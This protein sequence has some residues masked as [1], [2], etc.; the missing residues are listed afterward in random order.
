M[1]RL[2]ALL[3]VTALAAAPLARA[4]DVPSESAY[5][6]SR[7]IDGVEA[8][9]QHWPADDPRRREADYL[10]RQGRAEDGSGEPDECF[11]Y[12]ERVLKLLNADVVA[13]PGA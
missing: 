5:A 6:C 4:D 3:I 10:L 9:L 13:D 12:L 8:R 2:S 1:P 7:A 11:E